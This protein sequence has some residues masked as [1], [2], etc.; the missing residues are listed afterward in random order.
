MLEKESWLY[1][2]LQGRTIVFSRDIAEHW[3]TLTYGSDV[4]RA[5][6]A[7]IGQGRAKSEAFHITASEPI[8]WSEVLKVYLDVLDRKMGKSPKILMVEKAPSL[9]Y[10]FGKYQ[11]KYDRLFNRTFDNSKINRFIDTNTFLSPKE[12]LRLCLEKFVE[13]PLNEIFFIPIYYLMT[14]W[15]KNI[16]PMSVVYRYL[17]LY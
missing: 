1:R 6:S 5:M 2:A 12:G 13:H 9:Q 7:L 8:L 3:T 10:A 16:I 17:F 14:L 11:V 15:L 4:A